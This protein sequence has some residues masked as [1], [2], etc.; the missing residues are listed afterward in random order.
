MKEKQVRE[1]RSKS[2]SISQGATAPSQMQVTAP[3]VQGL[4]G[5]VTLGSQMASAKTRKRDVVIPLSG[6]Q[7]PHNQVLEPYLLSVASEWSLEGRI[8]A[9]KNFS[10]WSRQLRRSVKIL[11]ARS[12]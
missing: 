12:N 6:A 5:P 4:D 1:N 11:T 10:N 9:I 7:L 3:T 8:Q 2:G